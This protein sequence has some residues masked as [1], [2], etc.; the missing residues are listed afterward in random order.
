MIF[1]LDKPRN[2]RITYI[3]ADLYIIIYVCVCM[4]LY[5][6]ACMHACMQHTH[7]HIWVHV[8]CPVPTTKF[9]SV[10]ASRSL[11]P[12][13][14]LQG[15]AD[16]QLRM[17]GGATTLVFYVSTL[18]TYIHACMHT[19]ISICTPS[20]NPTS[21]WEMGTLINIYIY[22]NG[23]YQLPWFSAGGY[24]YVYLVIHL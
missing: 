24:W 19:Y 8:R 1:F 6:H 15:F 11:S 12:R 16:S 2:A 3:Y 18:T 13:L 5:L 21:P 23:H 20:G 17:K 7:I 4:H 9:R 22:I 10:H 14:D